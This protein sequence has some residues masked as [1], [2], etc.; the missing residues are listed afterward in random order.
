VFD[1]VD[2]QADFHKKQRQCWVVDDAS[3][4]GTPEEAGRA[5]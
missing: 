5:K 4:E 3:R 1:E 2:Q